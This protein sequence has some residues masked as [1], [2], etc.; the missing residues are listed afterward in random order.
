M[1][2]PDLGHVLTPEIESQLLERH[3]AYLNRETKPPLIRLWDKNFKLISRIA[4]PETWD[5]EELAHN[6]G[7]ATIEIVGEANAWLRE[8]IVYDTK[9]EEDLFITFDFDPDKPH[10]WRNR[11]GGFVDTI[12]DTEEQGKATRTVLKCLHGRRY[13]ETTLLASN[14]VFPQEIQLPKMFLWGGPTATACASALWI[15]LFRL[16]TLNG[17]FPLPRNLFAPETYLENVSPLNWPVQVMPLNPITDQS[18]WCTLGAKWKDAHTIFDPLLKNAGVVAKVYCWLPGDPPPYT[19]FGPLADVL[20]PSRAC[21]IVDFQNKSGVTG[22]TGTALDGGMNL[23]A[24]T[25]DDMI[26]EFLFPLDADGDGETDPFIRRLLGVAPAPPPIVYRDAGYGGPL[27][28]TMTI[29][30]SQATDIVTGGKSPQWVNQA[31]TF[32]IRY[33]LSQLA[34]T[35]AFYGQAQGTEGLDNL[36]QGQLDD[37]FLAYMRWVDPRRS[38]TVGPYARREYF[39][40]GTG[41][42]YT[43]NGVQSLRQGDYKCQAYTT[44]KFDVLD[45]FP[46]KLG[47]DFELGDRIQAERR[48]ILHTDQVL[49]IRRSGG[50]LISHRPLISLGDDSREEDPISRGFA[51]IANVA[52]FAALLAGSGD[53]F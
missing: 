22:W 41:S 27:K 32:A 11:W 40:P 42:A 23:I 46:Y 50:R 2:T 38:A 43:I 10:D 18:R 29:H 8:I 49:A 15:N 7:E 44:F 12:T 4:L 45:G 31:I 5:A 21:F 34:Q 1:P 25:A 6:A 17:F 20:K 3:H 35:I 52:N 37:V 13:L 19:M 53:M 14:P 39:E 26:T 36:Y 28:S 48:G 47:E 33:A 51:Q 16:Y 24:A 30:K 9:P